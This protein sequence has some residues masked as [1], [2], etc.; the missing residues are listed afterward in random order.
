MNVKKKNKGNTPTLTN[1]NVFTPTNTNIPTNNFEENW[2]TDEDNLI[3]LE[4]KKLVE[5]DKIYKIIQI[6]M[7][8]PKLL[9]N[10]AKK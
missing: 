10:Q 8:I 6:Q 7:L 2:N 3:E 1:T 9:K 4:K 5:G